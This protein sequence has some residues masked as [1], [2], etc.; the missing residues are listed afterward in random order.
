MPIVSEE[1]YDNTQRVVNEFGRHG[2]LGEKLQSI[3]QDIAQ[4]KDN[5]V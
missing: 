2:G 4:T 3:L 5:W 1:A